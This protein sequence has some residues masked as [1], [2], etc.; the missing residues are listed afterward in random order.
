MKKTTT[1][2]YSLNNGEF[3]RDIKNTSDVDIYYLLSWYNKIDKNF[4]IIQLANRKII[5]S[6]LLN[7]ELYSLSHEPE[8]CHNH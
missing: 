3:I 4:Y 7:D 1:K 8:N 2:I 6:N 5:I